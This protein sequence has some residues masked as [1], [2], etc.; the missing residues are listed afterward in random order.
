MRRYLILH[1]GNLPS[2]SVLFTSLALFNMLIGPLNAFPWVVNGLVE[3]W[4]SHKR[5]ASLV[6]TP[7]R[8]SIIGRRS[9]DP[10]VPDNY[11]TSLASPKRDSPLVELKHAAW[12]WSSGGDEEQHHRTLLRAGPSIVLRCGQL[13]LLLGAVGSGKSSLMHGIV[14]VVWLK[15][16]YLSYGKHRLAT[17]DSIVAKSG[18]T[19]RYQS[20]RW[21]HKTPG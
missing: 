19:N 11:A 5:I 3:A 20:S 18:Y 13:T 6:A 16:K 12:T 21:R 17:C 8:P 7:D 10:P 1:H 4:V 9:C 14:R 15:R 2:A